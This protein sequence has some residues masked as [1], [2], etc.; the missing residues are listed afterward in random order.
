MTIW[1]LMD[2]FVFSYDFYYW[3]GSKPSTLKMNLMPTVISIFL[4]VIYCHL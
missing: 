1:S 4:W 3:N 2:W